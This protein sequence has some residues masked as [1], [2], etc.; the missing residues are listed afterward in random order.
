MPRRS[1][2]RRS[3]LLL[4]A[5]SLL[6]AQ[7][8]VPDFTQFPVTGP[9][10]SGKP[11]P[12]VLKTAYQRTFRT[13]IR[14]SSADGPNF[15]GHFT[16]AEWGCGAGCVSVVVI[17]AATGAIYNGPFRNL[18]WALRKYENRIASNDD[19]FEPLEYKRDSRLLVAR[20]CPQENN[21]ASYFWEWTGAE[22]KLLR[23]IPSVPLPGEK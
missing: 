12:P 9:K 17:D 5:L 11:A 19:K 13:R 16:V 1:L 4:Y 21:C 2:T 10:F 6:R 22:F 20:G 8:P 7:G 14:E 15:A 23:K 3:L 18:A